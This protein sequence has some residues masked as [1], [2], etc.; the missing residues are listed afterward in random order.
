MVPDILN[1]FTA[2]VN[3]PV[4]DAWQRTLDVMALVSVSGRKQ[5]FAVAL[6]LSKLARQWP[7]PRVPLVKAAEQSKDPSRSQWCC[8]GS[9]GGVPSGPIK[10]SV[11]A[12]QSWWPVERICLIVLHQCAEYLSSLG[13]WMRDIPEALR[14]K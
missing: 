6:V 11:S 9:G 5:K 3:F 10:R 8:Q 4:E 14:Q 2:L 1:K 12:G 7:A 13:S